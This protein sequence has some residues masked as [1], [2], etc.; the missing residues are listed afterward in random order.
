MVSPFSGCGVLRGIGMFNIPLRS[1]FFN[2]PFL[3]FEEYPGIA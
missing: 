1:G 3:L 2:H